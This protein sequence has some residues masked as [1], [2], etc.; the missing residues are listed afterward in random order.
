MNN[1]LISSLPWTH[2]LTGSMA[3]FK[4]V[5]CVCAAHENKTNNCSFSWSFQVCFVDRLSEVNLEFSSYPPRISCHHTLLFWGHRWSHVWNEVGWGWMRLDVAPC[6]TGEIENPSNYNLE[7]E[8]NDPWPVYLPLIRISRRNWFHET[9][10][11]SLLW[12]STSFISKR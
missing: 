9:T 7:P 1:L 4:H 2:Q 3:C 6:L 11:R 8:S 10:D 5:V 12:P